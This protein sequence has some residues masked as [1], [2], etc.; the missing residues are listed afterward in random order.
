VSAWI[1][2]RQLHA[3]LALASTDEQPC[4]SLNSPEQD[5]Q[6]DPHVFCIQVTWLGL[7]IHLRARLVLVPGHSRS[8]AI[9]I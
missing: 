3:L 9:E 1:K 6:P 4:R 8:V 7:H 5:T 2:I